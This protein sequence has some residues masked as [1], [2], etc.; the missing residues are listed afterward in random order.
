[1]KTYTKEEL[2]E[3]ITKH[4]L[5][6]DDEEGGERANLSYSD[7]HGSNLL[8]S[9]LRYSN[10]SGSNLSD[11]DLSRID[12][13][14]SDLRGSNLSGSNLSG[15]NL[16]GSNLSDSDLSDSDLRYS[17]LSDSDLR[18]SNLRGSNLSYSNLRYSNLHRS[19]LSGSNLRYLAT[20]ENG[21][22]KTL[23]LGK[24]YTTISKDCICVGCQSHTS[25]EWQAFTDRE[26]LE[27]GG[28]EG[29]I[30][31]KQW[32]PVIFQVHATI[33]D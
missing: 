18:Y 14:G 13:R 31:W 27:M 28:K 2:K 3:I 6:L 23:Q 22:I 9:D 12:L 26:I 24:Y 19:D 1:M 25:E 29:L 16:L 8:G 5:W 11:S 7:L 21:R 4:K 17:N 33:E 32:Q 30:W 20:G 15:S 10:L